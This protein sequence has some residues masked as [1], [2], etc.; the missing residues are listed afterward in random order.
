MIREQ[1]DLAFGI[2]SVTSRRDSASI[3]TSLYVPGSPSRNDL[4]GTPAEILVALLGHGDA[5]SD[6]EARV[7]GQVFYIER[8]RSHPCTSDVSCHCWPIPATG[9]AMQEYGYMPS[10]GEGRRYFVSPEGR[11]LLTQDFGDLSRQVRRRIIARLEGRRPNRNVRH[12]RG[13]K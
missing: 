13:I 12:G 1:F 9:W 11:V 3:P 8:R 2:H 4:T 10:Y 5:L 6:L 7:D